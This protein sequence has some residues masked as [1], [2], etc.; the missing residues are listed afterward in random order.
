MLV[1]WGGRRERQQPKLLARPRTLPWGVQRGLGRQT[2]FRQTLLREVL[3]RLG[4][5]CSSERLDYLRP[6]EH[7]RKLALRGAVPN[8]RVFDDLAETAA[9]LVLANDVRRD[10]LLLGRA[11][12]EK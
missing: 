9:A 5:C 1:P 8:V 11:C 4:Y 3:L 12:E 6:F 7:S 10:S 2:L